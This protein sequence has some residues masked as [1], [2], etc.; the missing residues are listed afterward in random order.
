MLLIVYIMMHSVSVE[1]GE[2]DSKC[3]PNK[4]NW[5]AMMNLVSLYFLKLVLHVVPH[6]PPLELALILWL[7]L[8]VI[9][10]FLSSWTGWYWLPAVVKVIRREQSDRGPQCYASCFSYSLGLSV[11]DKVKLTLHLHAKTCCVIFIFFRLLLKPFPLL[12]NSLKG[13][14]FI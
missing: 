10:T 4:S 5:A 1:S 7:N 8:S 11:L 9:S 12:P 3:I 2:V 6:V 13:Y 14:S